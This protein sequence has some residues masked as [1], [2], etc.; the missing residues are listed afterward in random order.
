[1]RLEDLPPNL[2][3]Q[4]DA[5]LGTSKRK[6]TTQRGNSVVCDAVCWGCGTRWTSV[7]LWERHSDET[8]HRRLE[9]VATRAG[10]W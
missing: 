10:E 3:S 6:R 5:K 8:G 2:R 4:V 9:S 1:M 7:A